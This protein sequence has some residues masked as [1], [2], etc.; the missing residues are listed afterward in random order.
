MLW[1]TFTNFQRYNYHDKRVRWKFYYRRKSTQL[2]LKMETNL[3]VHTTVPENTGNCSYFGTAN[4]LGQV[5]VHIFAPN[6]GYC[7]FNSRAKPRLRLWIQFRAKPAE[8]SLP[9]SRQQ[10]AWNE[11]HLQWFWVNE[12]FVEKKAE[13]HVSNHSLPF[14]SVRYPE[15]KS[16]WDRETMKWVTLNEVN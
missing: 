1:V 3:F 4:A 10:S 14:K 8:L 15:R 9:G 6:G 5:S 11:I 16:R 13:F 12:L 7:S 2:L